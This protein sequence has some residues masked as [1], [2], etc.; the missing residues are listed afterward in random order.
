M[1]SVFLLKNVNHS[2]SCRCYQFNRYCQLGHIP[3][4]CRTGTPFHSLEFLTDIVLLAVLWRLRSKLSLRDVAAMVLERGF[5]FPHE[6]LRE[7]ETRFAPRRAEQVRTR[8]RGQAG[9]SWE[10]DETYLKVH[11]KWCEWY[12][13]IASD[14]NLVDSRLSEKRNR[15]AA[16]PFFQQAVGV[17]GPIPDPMTTDGHMSYAR[18]RRETMSSNVQHRTN[19][20]LNNRLQPGPSRN[21]A[22]L[23]SHAWLWK[24]CI[25]HS[26]LLCL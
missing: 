14:G 25:S 9:T 3:E 6:A 24:R 8:R 2:I 20:Y 17:V 22:T 11:G 26:L 12:R 13:A 19:K 5:V 16:K 4:Q 23:F 21:Q 10:V 15:E 7:G 18:A 1:T